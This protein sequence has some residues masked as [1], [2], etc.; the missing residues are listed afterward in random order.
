MCECESVS[1]SVSV[2]KFMCCFVRTKLFQSFESQVCSQS[3]ERAIWA[4]AMIENLRITL[5]ARVHT[6]AHTCTHAFTSQA[7]NKNTSPTHARPHRSALTLIWRGA[8]AAMWNVR[9]ASVEK[10]HLAPEGLLPHVPL[11]PWGSPAPFVV[12]LV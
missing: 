8:T 12:M 3:S 7:T 11:L 2:S 9:I 6:C 4:W 10:L 1:V 5:S